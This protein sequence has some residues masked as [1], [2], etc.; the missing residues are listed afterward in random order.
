MR[1]SIVV[2]THGRPRALAECLHSLASLDYPKGE[3]EVIVVDDGSQ[4]DVA[5][6]TRRFADDVAI[7]VIN[8][9]RQTG[10]AAA[11]NV[12]AR[13]G[14]GDI[15]AFTDDDCSA[16]RDWLRALDSAFPAEPGS[17]CV[18]GRTINQLGGNLY[19]TATHYLLDFLFSWYNRDAQNATFFPT[20]N[21]A[22]GRQAFL[23]MG[24]FDKAFP[25][26]AAEDRDFC[27][28]WRE[29]GGR[30]VYDDHAIVRHV[31]RLTLRRFL[32]QHF[33]YGRGAVYLH[34]ARATRGAARSRLE[35]LRFYRR[36]VLYAWGQER[37]MRTP[38]L[39]TPAALTQLSYAC[40]YYM[41]RFRSPDDAGST[42]KGSGNLGDHD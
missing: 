37:R 7:R 20:L 19:S 41:E 29:S 33:S 39:I 6:V 16:D 11:R 9:R 26:A 23:E 3:R 17:L 18:G 38:L 4:Y 14:R 27:D 34:S 35:P 13:E 12:G 31:H 28:R 30:L 5:E 25:L 1:F 36:L 42:T 10:P 32:L 2:P 24:G 8:L 15:V 22:C 21:L 40:G